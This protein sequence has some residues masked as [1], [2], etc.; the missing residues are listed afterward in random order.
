MFYR[1]KTVVVVGGGNTAV[2]AARVLSRLSKQETLENALHFVCSQNVPPEQIIA[3]LYN[4][5]TA[6]SGKNGKPAEV[7]KQL[8]QQPLP[9]AAELAIEHLQAQCPFP[10]APK[11]FAPLLDKLELPAQD[12]PDSPKF[13]MTPRDISTATS[14]ITARL[15]KYWDQPNGGNSL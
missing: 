10:I 11:V 1:N 2:G 4:S 15:R 9:I 5:S 7:A 6:V 12:T 3:Y 14:L 13:H 8:S